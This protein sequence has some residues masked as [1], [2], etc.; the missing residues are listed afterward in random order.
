MVG[1][2]P[3]IRHWSWGPEWPP[4]A[5]YEESRL[6]SAGA[7]ETSIPLGKNKTGAFD[8]L[9]ATSL[10][11]MRIL[12]KKEAASSQACKTEGTYMYSLGSAYNST[13]MTLS[14]HCVQIRHSRW[15]AQ[16]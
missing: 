6:S 5:R 14:W 8:R 15:E 7:D 16:P 12:L 10:S 2:A 4:N 1:A 3:I 9:C 11:N 13:D